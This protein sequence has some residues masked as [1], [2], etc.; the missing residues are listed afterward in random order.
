[1]DGV[2]CLDG[3]LKPLAV[4]SIHEVMGEPDKQ[5]PP[6]QQRDVDDQTPEQKLTEYL[7]GHDVALF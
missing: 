5:E 7:D 3:H 4:E 2:E 6:Q 1:M